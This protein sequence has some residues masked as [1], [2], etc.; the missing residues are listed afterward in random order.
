MIIDI[1]PDTMT[2]IASSISG[3]HDA[4]EQASS[5]LHSIT[6]HQDWNCKERDTINEDIIANAKTVLNINER[7]THFGNV[8][9]TVAEQF[10]TDE[11]SISAMFE[12]VDTIIGGL[13]TIEPVGQPKTNVS[14]DIPAMK[15][16]GGS[17]PV[18]DL[19]NL[20]L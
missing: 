15:D 11:S 8:M 3:A 18:V 2:Q 10:V 12:N 9:R 5:I 4:V 16:V 13:L 6:T 20:N 7:M 14:W 17:I 1:N 19:S